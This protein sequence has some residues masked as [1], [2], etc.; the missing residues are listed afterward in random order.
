MPWQSRA[1]W[2]SA[3]SFDETARS[4]STSSQA[5]GRL[6]DIV[7]GMMSKQVGPSKTWRELQSTVIPD[8]AETKRNRGY[9]WRRLIAVLTPTINHI[10]Q[11]GWD[12]TPGIGE[13]NVENCPAVMNKVRQLVNMKGEA[14]ND[15]RLLFC[16]TAC[17]EGLTLD[18]GFLWNPEAVT[19]VRMLIE[20]QL[21]NEGA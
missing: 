15:V 17:N 3:S 14:A 4:R 10:L 20:Q 19:A 12:A 2:Q 21:Y 1:G 6:R 7:R 18:V 9:M 8:G 13:L 11:G 16:Q 5:E